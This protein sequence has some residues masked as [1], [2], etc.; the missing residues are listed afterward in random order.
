MVNLRRTV[1]GAHSIIWGTPEYH[2]GP[3]GVLKNALDLMGFDEFQG[4][5]VGL[6]GTSGGEMGATNAL[7][8][9]RPLVGLCGPG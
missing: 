4:K 8:S 5:V 2:G 3:S 9:P 1:Q 6:V 7:N